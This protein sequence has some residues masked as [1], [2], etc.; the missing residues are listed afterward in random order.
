MA[1]LQ[2][3]PPC[4]TVFRK[5]HNI[6]ASDVQEWLSEANAAGKK[7]GINPA[8]FLAISIIETDVD[9]SARGGGMTQVTQDV[10]DADNAM[11]GTNYTDADCR[12][13]GTHVKTESGAVELT[14]D[15]LGQ[16]LSVLN[17]KTHS[18]ALSATGR[19]GAICGRNGSCKPFG[20]SA[21]SWPI[22][23][24][25]SCY[26]NAVLQLASAYDEWWSDPDT[27]KANSFY[28]GKLK[29]APTDAL[30]EETWL[31]GA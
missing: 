25:S 11:N 30:P 17:S 1:S 14:F 4:S 22:P 18:I 15:I 2:K 7:H 8:V 27:G 31:Y 12:G 5:V 20:S 19:N 16:Y 9:P 24:G 29:A 23:T 21:D 6:T 3:C 13:K 26:G 10:L 28:F